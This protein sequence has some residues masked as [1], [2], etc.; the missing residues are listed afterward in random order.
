[1]ELSEHLKPTTGNSDTGGLQ[2]VEGHES[3]VCETPVITC[4]VPE[5]ISKRL[6]PPSGVGDGAITNPVMAAFKLLSND[7]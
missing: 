5:V 6:P 7:K 3:T 2:S 4:I 1:V